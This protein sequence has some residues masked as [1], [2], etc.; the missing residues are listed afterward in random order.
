MSDAHN[1]HADCPSPE[2]LQRVAR[3]TAYSAAEESVVEQHLDHC[4][5]CRQRFDQLLASPE[6]LAE[7]RGAASG[8]SQ[9]D[10][11]AIRAAGAIPRFPAA[12]VSADQVVL[13]CGL[14]LGPPRDRRFLGRL[15]AYDI[16]S[17]LGEGGMGVVLKAH[18]ESLQRD[19]ALKVMGP[20]VSSDPVARARFVR[21]AQCAAKLVHQSIITIHA[22][23]QDEPPMI[24]MEFVP[25]KSL[26]LIIE[27]EGKLD[28]AR[29]ARI[30]RQVLEALKY[31]HGENVVHRDVKPANILLSPGREQAKLVDFGLARGVADAVR[32]TMEG[33]IVGTPWYM[34]P[35]QASGTTVD[36]RS[37]LFSLGV[38]LFEALTGVVPFPG[39]DVYKVLERIRTESAPDVNELNPLAPAALAEIVARALATD[40]NRRYA[41]AAEFADA[42]DRFLGTRVEEIQ[43]VG[44]RA[45]RKVDR[46]ESLPRCSA[47]GQTVV[48]KLSMSGGCELCGQPICQ[49]CWH[50]LRAKRCRE[51]A[52]QIKASSPPAGSARDANPAETI[53]S[54]SARASKPAET[55]P[56]RDQSPRK[57]AAPPLASAKSDAAAPGTSPAK[58]SAEEQL[59]LRREQLQKRVDA[60]RAAGRPAVTGPEALLAEETFLRL[61]ENSLWPLSEITDPDRNTTIP[62]KNWS[63]CV[64][65]LTPAPFPASIDSWP[66]EA[67]P[68]GAAAQYDL[69]KRGALGGTLARVVIEARSLAR[70]ARFAQQGYDDE[71]ATRM[72]LESLLNSAASRA[73]ASE[74]WHLL[75][76]FSPTGWTA[77]ARDF[78]CG[79]GTRSFRDRLTSVALF[80]SDAAPFLWN[81]TDEKLVPFREAFAG[82]MDETTLDRVRRFVGEYL[83]LNNS[84]SLDTLARDVNISRKAALRAMKLLALTGPYAVAVLDEVGVVLTTKQ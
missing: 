2:L 56:S 32:H 74:A 21:E 4:E 36:P 49:K 62:V 7:L 84:I 79:G 45:V 37:D 82:E 6:E 17:V 59:R 27:E 70:V 24:V 38:V 83:E 14:K 5:S 80:D 26:A 60:S 55:M 76:L 3:G 65:R 19:V 22:V 25:G 29:A 16:I 39:Q 48:S 42:I 69:R 41:S 9:S 12:N 8:D 43:A 72:E 13:P 46:T 34:S 40:R 63:K 53:D 81:A 66:I 57:P 54:R 15:G 52:S 23:S 20:R 47:C 11:E 64:E 73:A 77:E 75:I 10:L 61:V 67:C 18:E 50:V 58:A 33:S 44:M 68:S 51:H 28:A 31:A 78:A 1:N 71:P 30:V 35:E